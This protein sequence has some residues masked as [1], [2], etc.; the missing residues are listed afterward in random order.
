M[1][2]WPSYFVDGNDLVLV[3]VNIVRFMC[4]NN[5]TVTYTREGAWDCYTVEPELRAVS[6]L[7]T[8][9]EAAAGETNVDE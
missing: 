5:G 1:A 8:A 7:Q 2:N 9:H 6:I 4:D 3:D